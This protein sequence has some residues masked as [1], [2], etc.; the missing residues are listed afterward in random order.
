MLLASMMGGEDNFLSGMLE[1]IPIV[2]DLFTMV[3]DLFG[4]IFEMVGLDGLLGGGS[5]DDGKSSSSSSSEK[6]RSRNAGTAAASAD[7]G[8]SAAGHAA[9]LDGAAEEEAEM[10]A[11]LS[12]LLNMLRSIASGNASPEQLSGALTSTLGELGKGDLEG[13]VGPEAASQ[14]QAAADMGM[15]GDAAG[16]ADTATSAF[17][18]TP[19]QMA[20]HSG[21]IADLIPDTGTQDM[22][23][24]NMGLLGA[25]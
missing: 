1:D 12:K 22:G 14:L 20:T 15:S 16:M 13:L 9:E 6:S 8:A 24:L 25:A 21:T 11:Q 23:D 4:G 3:M 18:V 17:G 5:D 7:L 19:E 2:G 10:K